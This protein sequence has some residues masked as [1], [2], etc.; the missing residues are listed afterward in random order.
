MG[1]ERIGTRIVLRRMANVVVAKTNGVARVTLNRPP[2][3]VIDIPLMRELRSA[4]EAVTADR[5]A[6]VVVV[7]A[8]GKAFSAGVDIKDHTPDRVDEMLR[9]FHAVIRTLW[10][11]PAPTV[12]AVRGSALGGG[13]ELA[14]SCD[15]IV[16]SEQARFGQPEIQV[17]AFPPI[18]AL[19]LARQIPRKKALE[20][21]LTGDSISA[22]QA[23][24]FGL[25]NV[26]APADQFDAAVNAFIARLSRWSGPVLKLAKRAAL[27]PLVDGDAQALREIER[28]Y[29]QELM[30]TE[31]AREGTQAF[32]DKRQ[33]EWKDR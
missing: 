22:A 25:V 9:E 10:A 7:G 3:N 20:L 6:K 21:I 5:E 11:S 27:V 32:L 29:L 1:M 16:A 30:S 4:L 13:M 14:L 19:L 24:P 18:A 17:G 12:A 31:D 15:L 26:V 28:I 8:E 33:P 2:L 23:G